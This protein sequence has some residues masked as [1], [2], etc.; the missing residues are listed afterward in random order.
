[1]KRMLAEFEKI[2]AI[3]MAFPHEFG[4]W[5]YCIKEARES[6]LNIIQTIAKHAQVLVCVHTSDTIGYEMLKNLPGVEIARIDTNDTWARDFGAISIENQ[7]VLECLD[8]GFNGW[9]LKYPS[10]LDN[11]VNFKL[12][13]LGFLK[14]PLKTMPYILEGGSIESDGAGSVLTNPNK[15]HR[16]P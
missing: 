1:M 9:G 16:I 4:D 2:Q 14:H 6:F 15:R 7:G 8:F 12:K 5:A 11:R 10:N 3:L 13:N